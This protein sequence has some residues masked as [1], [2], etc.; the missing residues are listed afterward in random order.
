MHIFILIRNWSQIFQHIIINDIAKFSQLVPLIKTCKEMNRHFRESFKSYR[1]LCDRYI[2]K[3][4]SYIF[5]YPQKFYGNEYEEQL[6]QKIYHINKY[7]I[8]VDNASYHGFVMILDYYYAIYKKYN[9]SLNYTYRSIN[10]AIM[11]NHVDVLEWFFDRS[12]YGTK[13]ASTNHILIFK[14]TQRSI[15]YAFENRHSQVLDWFLNIHLNQKIECIF[16]YD[17]NIIDSASRDGNLFV[18][19]WYYKHYLNDELKLMYSEIS[20]N[21]AVEQGHLHVLEWF[22][23]R[24]QFKI[25]S[26]HVLEFKYS[27]RAMNTAAAYNHIHILDWFYE[28]YIYHDLPLKYNF[29]ALDYVLSVRYN[30]V[31]KWFFNRASKEWLKQ[32]DLMEYYSDQTPK[33]EMKYNESILQHFLMNK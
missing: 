3:E 20:I 18:H 31:I 4:K 8:T 11:N 24:S 6:F 29:S 33:I 26:K 14:F 12:P 9:K 5:L 30:N 13:Y 16:I 19:D 21:S 15:K 23:N 10:N 1:I 27:E 2:K 17:E 22:F 25:K 32:Y 7:K 28:K